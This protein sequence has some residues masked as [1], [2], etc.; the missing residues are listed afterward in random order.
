MFKQWFMAETQDNRILFYARDREQYGFLSNFHLAPFELDGQRWPSVEHYYVAAKSTNPNF[1]Q[2]ILATPKPGK[3]KRLGY[4]IALR[5]DWEQV[6]LSVM[7]RAVKAKFT[8]NSSLAQALKATGNMELVEDSPTD[9]I[10]GVGADGTGKNWLGKIL[11]Q[12]RS[13]L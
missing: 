12:V 11:M 8:Q 10:W 6:K 4:T 3:V 7:F 2:Q 13:Q 9:A 5:P 1:T